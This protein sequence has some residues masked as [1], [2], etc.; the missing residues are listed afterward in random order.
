M[1]H[2]VLESNGPILSLTVFR[3]GRK[4]SREPDMPCKGRRCQEFPR[5]ML[6]LQVG[7]IPA[8]TTLKLKAKYRVWEEDLLV[9]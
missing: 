7:T 2:T 9:L 1:A 3:W 8:V 5:Q 4:K 6:Q